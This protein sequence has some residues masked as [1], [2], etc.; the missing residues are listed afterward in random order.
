[1]KDM[2][3]RTLWIQDKVK[4]F[5]AE[6]NKMLNPKEFIAQ[7]IIG[8]LEYYEDTKTMKYI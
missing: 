2:K 1:M 4:K 8:N 5:R 7:N 3:D 6:S